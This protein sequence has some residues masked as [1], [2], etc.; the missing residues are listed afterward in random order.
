MEAKGR[1]TGPRDVGSFASRRRADCGDGAEGE[2][3]APESRVYGGGRRQ[4]YATE[5]TSLLALL[6]RLLVGRIRG[7]GRYASRERIRGS[8]KTSRAPTEILA[9][10][11]SLPVAF[12][13]GRR[14]G[15]PGR[16]ILRRSFLRF[17]LM[18]AL[19]YLI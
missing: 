5:Y 3:C 10:R 11:F 16:R 6:F 14:D 12:I 19:A 2:R 18:V 8:G 17:A 15:M 13:F 7:I 9:K 4:K 1:D